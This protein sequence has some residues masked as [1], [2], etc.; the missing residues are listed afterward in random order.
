MIYG[1]GRRE[2]MPA[3]LV[4]VA[5]SDQYG[6]RAYIAPGARVDDGALDLVAVGPVT[7]FNAL[8]LV[9][10][11]FLG[12]LDRSA[13]VLRLRD[14]RFLI[15]RSVPGLIHTDGETHE[16]GTMVDVVVRPRSLRLVVPAGSCVT[17]GAAADRG[18]DAPSPSPRPEVA[19][20]LS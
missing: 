7:L 5:N 9:A 16:T 2:E 14:R 15:V 18:A 11:L 10:R 19:A 4:A 6:N 17:P 3:F 1:A 12:T 20:R 13:L 8:P